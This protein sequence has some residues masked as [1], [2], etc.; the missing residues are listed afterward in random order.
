MYQIN[1]VSVGI[2]RQGA[3]IVLVK[4]QLADRPPIWMLPGGMVEP[5]ELFHEALVREV[6]EETG[7]AV[8]KIGGLVYAM[9][10]D[11]PERCEQ[12]IAYCFEIDQWCGALKSADPDNEILDVQL[13]ALADAPALLSRIH[14]TAV[15]EPLLAYLRGECP[16]G[17]LWFY[18]EL[19]GVQVLLDRLT[20]GVPG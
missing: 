1:Q 3:N 19:D 14:W 13:I 15:R 2:L 20:G 5:G 11:H 12:T 17:T 9:Q 10:I 4:Q 6:A 16:P 18:R 7:T 8:E